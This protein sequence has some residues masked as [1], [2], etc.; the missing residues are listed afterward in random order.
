[1]KQDANGVGLEALECG[2]L[3]AHYYIRM[4]TM[5]KICQAPLHSSIPDLMHIISNAEEMDTIR[6][7]R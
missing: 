3:M 7:R 6:L 5:I 1:M 2:K 4:K